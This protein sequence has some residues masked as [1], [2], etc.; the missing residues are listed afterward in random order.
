MEQNKIQSNTAK[1]NKKV[2]ESKAQ[3]DVIK[4]WMKD[5]RVCVSIFMT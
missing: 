2:W 4:L 5:H 1:M 3:E